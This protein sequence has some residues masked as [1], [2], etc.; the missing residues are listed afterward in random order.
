[1]NINIPDNQEK[2]NFSPK[3]SL[4]SF[5]IPALIILVAIGAFGL[6]RLHKIEQ[7]RTPITI[8]YPTSTPAT[9]FSTAS[10][11][12]GAVTTAVPIRRVYVASRTGSSY[13]LPSCAGANR[14][15]EKNKVWFETKAE[16]EKAGYKPAANC[17]G[18]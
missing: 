7:A 3:S 11:S 8:E 6:G 5:F 18:I 2:G 9:S 15:L 14:I 1:V 13:Y 4:Q 10:S 17:K 16:A 12:L